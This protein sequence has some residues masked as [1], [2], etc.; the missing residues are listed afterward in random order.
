VGVLLNNI[1]SRQLDSSRM[2]IPAQGKVRAGYFNGFETLVDRL[3]GDPHKILEHNCI[4][5]LVFEDPDND[6]EC[7]AAVGMLEYA[8]RHL[9]DPLFG[10]HLAEQQDP[11][12]FGC[13]IA[14]ARSAPTLRQALQCLIDYAPISASP[15]GEL[16]MV[17]VR[18]VVE[19]RWR[20]ANGLSDRG[21][22]N[23]HSVSLVM[24]TLKMLGKP[25]F[26]PRYASLT[27]PV[28]GQDSRLLAEH[29]GCRVYGRAAVNA[30]AFSTDIFDNPIPTANRTLYSMLSTGMSNL[31][32]TAK[33]S[34]LEQVEANVRRGIY[35]G[36][37]TLPDCA[38]IMG[39]S[40][41]TLQ[42]RLAEAGVKYIDVLQAERV[43]LAKH[44]LLWGDSTLG[45]IAIQLGYAEQTSFGRAFK[46]S[47][48]LTPKE[49]RQQQRG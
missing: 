32:A 10:L 16:E 20:A 21:Q 2:A 46:R 25:H 14:L 7:T 18:E 27:L 35:I 43:K 6:I 5:P 1:I 34:F 8:S 36:Q 22:V 11:D 19:F 40:V 42:K 29:L 30:I 48:G 15:E 26:R 47:T 28:A 13:V 4:N 44:S 41:R 45:D 23:Y 39:T 9:N 17:D 33:A 12:V 38:R 3:G 37:S 49:Y 31:R 24:K